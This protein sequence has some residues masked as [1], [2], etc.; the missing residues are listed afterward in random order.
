MRVTLESGRTSLI[1]SWA[2]AE[3]EN[4]GHEDNAPYRPIPI[5][6]EQGKVKGK[7]FVL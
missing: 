4:A 6:K 1:I 7:G 5:G 3:E 2:H